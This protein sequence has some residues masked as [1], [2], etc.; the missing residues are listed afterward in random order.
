MID[1]QDA[2]LT[3]A[4]AHVDPV[5]GA[6][7]VWTQHTVAGAGG[8]SVV[9]WYELLPAS[10]VVRQQGTISSA[11]QFVFN[12]AISPAINGTTAAINYNTGSSGQLVDIRAQSRLGSTALGQ[13]SGEIVLGTSSATDEDFSCGGAAT[14]CRWGD[15]AGASPDP[16]NEQAI[17]GS[18]QL[19]G[20]L[21]TDPAWRTRNFELTDTAAGYPRPEGRDADARVAR[22][23]VQPRAA[24][25][26][27]RTARRSRSARARRRSRPP[28]FLTVGTPDSNGADANAVA[29]IVLAT[30]VGDPAT[31]ADEADVKLSASSTDVRLKA[32][33]GDYTGQLQ[34]NVSLRLTDRASGPALDEPATVQDFTYRFTVPCQAT[35]STTVGSTCAV[36][37]TADAI[38]PGTVKETGTHDLAARPGPALRRRPGRR[39]LDDPGNTLFETQGV[40]VP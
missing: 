13:M 18:N 19:N 16:N 22:A 7:A 14:P 38:Q 9:R 26:T 15:Y 2:R 34:A 40:F 39:R 6:E 8:R 11:S 29:S 23:G 21:T 17:W 35:L 4:V 24:R 12:G 10:H 32:G 1:S 33:L 27:A 36:T 5:A 31:S 28:R 25:R 37:T 20:P 3:Q 30:V